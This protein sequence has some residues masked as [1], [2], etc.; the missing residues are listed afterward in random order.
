MRRSLLLVTA[1]LAGAASAQTVVKLNGFAGADV[2]IVN[3]LL[4][5]I[6]NPALAKDNIK[7]VFE[8]FQGDFNAALTNALSSGTAGDL[9]YIDIFVAPGFIKTGKLLPLNGKISTKPFVPS[10]VKAFTDSGKVY[11]VAKDF[12][13]LAI[14]F[15]K[16][17]F[18]EAD[19]AYPNENDTWSTFA[20]K[21]RKVKKALG[22]DYAGICLPADFARFGA[23]AFATGW[24]TFDSKGNSNLL[25]PRF[26]E[27]FNFYTGL[28]KDKTAILPSDLSQGW[29][30]GCFG[31]GKVAAAIEGAWI[32]GFLRDS[33]P[34]LKYGTAPI[35]KND[36]T[37][38]RGNF[39][40][41]VG[42]AV[43]KD[44]KNQAAAL[45]VLDQLTSEKTQQFILT[46][47]LAIPS[48]TSLQGNSYFNKTTQEAMNAK[49]VFN[50]ASDGYVYGYSFKQYGGDWMT[51]VNA[52][53]QAVM[54]GKSSVD[55]A[56]RKA[57]TELNS[58]MKR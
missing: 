2:A 22:N 4:N 44:S 17:L 13:S 33:A 23:F 52:A 25:D 5:K 38:K 20:D 48:R 6:V 9:M 21:L 28:V 1:L 30:G 39:I 51:P 32:S 27:A 16:D 15:N 29:S 36:K 49:V 11:A 40:F 55:E 24:K 10:L 37:K 34:N 19:V 35:P 3:D 26:K 53:L 58:V 18:D 41:T 42:W 43:N 47:G 46:E 7:A 57:Q 45:K 54:S 56:L 50:G 12:N 14:T 8:P 31:T